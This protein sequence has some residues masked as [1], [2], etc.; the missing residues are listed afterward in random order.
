MSK[1]W[2][3]FGKC[4][5]NLLLH[6]QEFLQIDGGFTLCNTRSHAYIIYSTCSWRST[7]ISYWMRQKSI[8]VNSVCHQF[9]LLELKMMILSHKNVLLNYLQSEAEDWYVSRR[10]LTT[11]NAH[12]L[13]MGTKKNKTQYLKAPTV[14][15][16]ILML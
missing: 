13:F 10:T 9:D 16:L 4:S 15:T 11:Y 14:L 5:K 8:N 12:F 3:E 6:S 7:H 1:D 2:L